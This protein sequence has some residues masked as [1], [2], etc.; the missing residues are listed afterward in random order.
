MATL[1]G[2]P[3]VVRQ[4]RHLLARVGGQGV[5]RIP[6]LRRPP[7]DGGHVDRPL[8][9]ALYLTWLLSDDSPTASATEN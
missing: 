7:R 8:T 9:G 3:G 5:A 2:P 1:G 4:A 6:S